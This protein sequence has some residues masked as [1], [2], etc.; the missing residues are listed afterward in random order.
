MRFLKKIEEIEKDEE[1]FR[2]E[3]NSLSNESRKEYFTKLNKKIV[4]PD[5]YATIIY[6]LYVGALHHLY[7]KEY[8]LFFMEAPFILIGYG[9]FFS[10]NESLS[11]VGFFIL[12]AIYIIEC[13]NLFF[14]QKIARIKNLDIGVN[15]FSEMKK[16]GIT[17]KE[18]EK[19][20]NEENNFKLENI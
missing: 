1:N 19:E 8:K 7:F 5:T 17:Y 9:L 14:S 11:I 13:P 10:T 18:K 6:L 2:K 12:F 3:I 20:N 4:D 16:N 15:I